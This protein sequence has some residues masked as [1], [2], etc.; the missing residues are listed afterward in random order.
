M[1][2]VDIVLV[3][4]TLLAAAIGVVMVYTATRGT[5]VANGLSPH[6]FLKRQALF[7]LLGLVGMVALSL[8]DYRRLES[9]GMLLYGLVVLSLLA[10]LV[11]GV[12]RHAL[13]SQRWFSL[14]PLQIQPSEFAV[15]GLILA[16]ATYCSRRS[17]GMTWSDVIKVLALAGVPIVL[18]MAQPDLGTAIIMI[19]VLLVMLAVAGIPGRILLLLVVGVVLAVLV[20]LDGGLLHHYQINRL[21]CFVNPK[22]CSTQNIYN[23]TQSKDAIGSGGMFGKGIFRGL[24]QPR[25][26]ARAAHR[27][28]LHGRR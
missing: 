22:Q 10:V 11:P 3:G 9:V 17:E 15:L 4:A 6:Y 5:L 12:G 24:H 14:G 16:V 18:V 7:V 23:L 8:V 27:L 2:G 26:R 21:T 28:H 25:L 20:A 13:G 19:I 1:L